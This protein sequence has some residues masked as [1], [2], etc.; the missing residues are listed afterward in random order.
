MQFGHNSTVKS[1]S[2]FGFRVGFRD[3]YGSLSAPVTRSSVNAASHYANAHNMFN[4]FR[5]FLI[6]I[7]N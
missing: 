3:Q 6:N 2:F 1:S 4:L 5:S 7:K